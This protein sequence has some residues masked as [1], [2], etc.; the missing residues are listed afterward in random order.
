[1]KKWK[2]LV[3]LGL[4]AAGAAALLLARRNEGAQPAQA[5]AGKAPANLKTGTY[6]F[7]SGFRNASTVEMSLDYDPEKFRFAVVS[8]EFLSYSSDSHVALVEGEDFSL[9]IEYAPYHAGE[10]ADAQWAFLREKHPDLSPAVYGGVEGVRYLEGDNV[11]FCFPIP[12]DGSSYVQ[13]IL[14]KAKGNDTP[15]ADMPADP[16]LTA[17]L[18]TLRFARS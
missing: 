5:P 10:E 3:P 7:I 13:V 1:M 12:E 14:F 17:L 9:Q 16:E 18:S 8:E 4:A 2:I 15:L 11:C 6:S